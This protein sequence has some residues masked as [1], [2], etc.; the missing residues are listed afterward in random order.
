MPNSHSEEQ[1]IEY[2]TTYQY[3]IK[4]S[5]DALRRSLMV[6]SGKVNTVWNYCNATQQKG[7]RPYRNCRP[8]KWFSGFDLNVLTTGT[9]KELNLHSEIV[10]SVCEEYAKKRIA[11]K[12]PWLKFRTNRKNRNL[13]WIPFKARSIKYDEKGTFTLGGTKLK[14]KTWY[15]RAIPENSKITNGTITMDN[16]GHWFIN[17]TFKYYLTEE[18]SLALTSKGQNLVGIDVGLNP[19]MTM[20]IEEPNGNI[21]YKEIIPPK[22]YKNTEKKL[23]IQQKSRRFKQA[24]KTHKKIK[25]HRK[26]FT[27]KLAKELIDNNYAI[28]MGI[29]DLN[30]LVKSSLK[31]HAKAWHDLGLGSLNAILKSKASKHNMVYHEVSEKE[32]KSTQT[33]SNCGS[34]TGP[35]GLKGLGVSDW[36]CTNSSCGK[37]HMRNE[38]SADNHRLAY[39]EYINTKSIPE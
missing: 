26:D 11:S 9:S 31:G 33:C 24:K 18:Q 22:Y 30:K 5:N 3:R 7:L 37:H 12:K 35:K 8:V 34:I 13:P 27:Y 21:S 10:N 17:I 25:N 15:S 14:L 6:L 28:S 19:L 23:G 38:N 16:L 39:K 29:V 2:L 20:S 32:L 4:D 1:L 36:V